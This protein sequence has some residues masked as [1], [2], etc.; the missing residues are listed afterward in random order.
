ME[1]LLVANAFD[2]ILE[3]RNSDAINVALNIG[4]LTPNKN[5]FNL[6]KLGFKGERRV[7]KGVQRFRLY[8]SKTRKVLFFMELAPK[9]SP[10]IIEFKRG[11]WEHLLEK[12]IKEKYGESRSEAEKSAPLKLRHRVRKPKSKTD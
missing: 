7:D 11:G 12:Y 4:L 10:N 8:D 2:T 3:R 5:T 6:P 9:S 1:T